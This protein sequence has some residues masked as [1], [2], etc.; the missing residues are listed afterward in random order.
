MTSTIRVRLQGAQDTIDVAYNAGDDVSLAVS[1]AAAQLGTLRRGQA[2][3]KMVL[4]KRD[5]TRA[6]VQDAAQ[7]A[8]QQQPGDVL[9][10]W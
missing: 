7:L 5:G 6:V 8:A 4:T 9:E 1:G 2:N 3:G 10:F